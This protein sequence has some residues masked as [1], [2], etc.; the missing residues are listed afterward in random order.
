M[1]AE[2]LPPYA[3]LGELGVRQLVAFPMCP[4]CGAPVRPVTDELISRAFDHI[5]EDTRSLMHL[6]ERCRRRRLQ[7]SL[8]IAAVEDPSEKTR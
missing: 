3:R 1:S 7:R 5:K 8:F 6:C 4:D 2:P